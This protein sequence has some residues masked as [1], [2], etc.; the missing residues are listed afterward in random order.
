MRSAQGSRQFAMLID[1]GDFLQGNPM[2]DYI[3]YEKGMK[4]GDVHPV[5]KGMNTLGYD[6]SARSAITNSTTASSFMFKV[7]QGANFPSSAPT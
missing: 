5:I 6:C 2:G 4:D 3:A 7:M 1:N